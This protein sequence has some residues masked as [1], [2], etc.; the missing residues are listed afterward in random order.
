MPPSK[1][2]SYSQLGIGIG[3]RKAHHKYILTNK[4]NVEWFE[5]ITENFLAD[6]G[7]TQEVLDEILQSYKIVMHAVSLYFGSPEM[8]PKEHLDRIKQLVCRTKT[9]WLTDH[10][11][12]G[13]VDGLYSHDLLPL[14]YSK[15]VAKMTAEKIKKIRDFLEVQIAVENVSSYAEFS[16]SRMSEWDFLNE[17]AEQADCGI[18]LDVNNIFVSSRNHNFDPQVYIDSVQHSRV[19]QIHIAGHCDKG[20]YIIDTHDRAPIDPVWSLYGYALKRC[21][22][23]ATLL[24]WDAKIPP[25]EDVYAEALKAKAWL[26]GVAD[27]RIDAI[28]NAVAE[29]CL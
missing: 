1:Y 23:T 26:D 21:G 3:L 6:G 17:V 20:R 28:G 18:L 4:P 25:F 12:W 15:E 7:R 19:V 9:P 8:P 5:I 29:G 22:H 11:C 16:A 13:S 27:L 14:P 10:L 24:E 2:N